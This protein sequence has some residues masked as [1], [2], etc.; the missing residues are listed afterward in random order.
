MAVQLTQWL[1][2]IKDISARQALRQIL[3]AIY[4]PLS[5]V[6][7][8]S[9]AITVSAATTVAT[10]AAW[11]G[12]VSASNPALTSNGARQAQLVQV[13]SGVAMPALVG[14]ILQNNFGLWLFII[15]AASVVSTSPLAQAATLA[16]IVYP[17][18]PQ[19]ST[20]I[21]GIVFNPTTATFIGGTTL[22]N[23]ASTNGVS[24][25]IAGAFDP[26]ATY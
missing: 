1:Q 20:V 22:T 24:I 2:E 13:A 14:T 3:S 4:E 17:A 18:V 19:G 25:N 16:G 5:S 12:A 11:I 23:A 6:S 10:G 7:L 8:A 26:T 15:N 21:G 9:A